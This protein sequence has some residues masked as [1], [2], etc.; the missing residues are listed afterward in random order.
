[1]I[2]LRRCRR[3]GAGYIAHV[4][5]VAPSTA[6]AILT[7]AGLGRVDCGDRATKAPPVRNV[8]ERPGELVHVD[9][10]KLPAIP[11]GGGWR[12][13]GRGA[14]AHSGVGYRYLHTAI[15]DC[16]RLAFSEDL[17]DE[18][19]ATAAGFWQRAHAF[20]AAWDITCERVLTDNGGCY[21]SAAWHTACAQTATSP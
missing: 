3:R 13:H 2:R 5:G 9:V 4:V 6:Q 16:I 19:G 20:F 7:D 15:D 8:S 21:R 17:D 11:P 14:A 10:K 18:T 12:A 1:M